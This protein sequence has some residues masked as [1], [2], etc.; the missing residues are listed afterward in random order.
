MIRV[1]RTEFQEFGPRKDPTFNGFT[2]IVV[3]LKNTTEW[4][5][6]SPFELRDEHGR[7]MENVF[8]GSKAYPNV[9]KRRIINKETGKIAFD[10]PAET[11]TDQNGKPNA[12][13]Y[14][15]RKKVMDCPYYLRYPAGFDNR[16]NCLCAFAEKPDGSIDENDRLDY[17]QSRKRIYVYEYCRL[18]KKEAKFQEL[19]D[20]LKAGENLLII[21]VDG[22]H[23]E[24]LNY[25][26]QKYGVGN[27]FIESS[28]MLVNKDNINVMLNDPKHPFGHGYCLAMA[29]LNKEVEWNV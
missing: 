20:R 12:K 13:Y 19:Q 7:I 17:I 28:T 4:G 2:N 23:Q 18:V 24:S 10:H 8:Q 5:P 11:H 26:K 15:W 22:P 16:H 14:G 21:E 27:D 3:L 1:G 29:L 9:P 25:Y 6:L